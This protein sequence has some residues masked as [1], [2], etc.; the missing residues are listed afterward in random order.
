MKL[1]KAY[2]NRPTETLKSFSSRKEE[3]FQFSGTEVYA[4]RSEILSHL[5]TMTF[6]AR[7]LGLKVSLRI[8]GRVW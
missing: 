1:S 5:L 4:L 2:P 8:S 3:T 7:Q 6:I